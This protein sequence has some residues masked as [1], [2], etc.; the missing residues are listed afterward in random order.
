MRPF[1]WNLFRCTFTWYYLIQYAV[2]TF[3]FVHKI[4]WCGHSSETSLEVLSH[5]TINLPVAQLYTVCGFEPLVVDILVTSDFHPLGMTFINQEQNAILEL[6]ANINI[7][8]WQHSE[9]N[10]F[11]ADLLLT[12]LQ[13]SYRFF[14]IFKTFHKWTQT[15]SALLIYKQ[16]FTFCLVPFKLQM[17]EVKTFHVCFQWKHVFPSCAH[18]A[19]QFYPWYKFSFLFSGGEGMAMHDNVNRK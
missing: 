6:K 5:S 14:F 10:V 17:L 16:L 8:N 12:I 2:L 4:L 1:K 19:L 9:P 3:E 15:R 7:D 13:P 18:V 11:L